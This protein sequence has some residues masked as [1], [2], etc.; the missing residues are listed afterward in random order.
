VLGPRAEGACGV[1]TSRLQRAFVKDSAAI[2]WE[3]LK[4]LRDEI[5]KQAML[6][7]IQRHG[8]PDDET[9]RS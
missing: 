3:E 4:N 1:G 6:E 7:Y 5:I 9:K 2:A 8:I